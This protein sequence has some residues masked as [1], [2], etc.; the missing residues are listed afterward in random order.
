MQDIFEKHN[1][2]IVHE[3][4]S[5]DAVDILED[6]YLKINGEEWNRIVQ[7][8]ATVESTSGSIFDLARNRPYKP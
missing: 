2:K 1:I 8:I 3:N 4:T 7:E 6:L 5:R